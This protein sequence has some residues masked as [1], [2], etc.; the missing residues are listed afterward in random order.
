M[1]ID[2]SQCSK[3]IEILHGDS[4]KKVYHVG[5]HI[6]EEA[7]IYEAN[8]VE[9]V[10]WFEANDSLIPTLNWNI[11]KYNMNQ[12]IIPYAL[13]DEN[14]TMKFNITNNMQSSSLFDL[15]KHL[16]Y[17]PQITVSEVKMVQAYRLD[18]LIN[19]TP[20]YLPWSDFD[21]INIDTQGAEL[22]VLKGLG[23]YIDQPSIKGI[24]IEVNFESLYK[25]IPLITEID[26]FLLLHRFHRMITKSTKDGWGDALYLKDIVSNL[27]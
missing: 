6:G 11:Q 2:F 27:E 7:S 1:L 24:Y 26:Q 15:D 14:K 18:A 5:A 13:F 12:L 17:Y 8:G 23:S 25:E 22:A 9:Q 16:L 21:F 19:V 20:R 4:V 10:I 3:L